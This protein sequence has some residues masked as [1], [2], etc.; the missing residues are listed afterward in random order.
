MA[1]DLWRFKKN[2]TR[3]VC[4]ERNVIFNTRQT[5]QLRKRAN[6][7]S[8]DLI[9]RRSKQNRDNLGLLHTSTLCLR[10]IPITFLEI[11]RKIDNHYQSIRATFATVYRRDRE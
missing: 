10:T 9:T 4:S 6:F 3:I 1:L 2:Q 8:R 11:L 5:L 7:G